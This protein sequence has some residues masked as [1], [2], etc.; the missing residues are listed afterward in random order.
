L[1]ITLV[2]DGS[3]DQALLPAV[4]WLLTEHGVGDALDARWADFRYR[5]KPPTDLKGKILTAIDL[6]PCDLLFVH[7]DAENASRER[8]KREID[9]IVREIEAD[10]KIPMPAVCVVPVRMMEAWLLVDE[11]AI[12]RA[13]GNPAGKMALG[14]PRINRIESTPDPKKALFDALATASGYT[15]RRLAKLNFPA[16]RYRVA[17]LISD[18]SQLRRLSAFTALEAEV[19][20]VLPL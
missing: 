2:S 14:L 6:Y 18:H 5:L 4:K 3:S 16:L 10:G 20:S 19:E 13:A 9:A 1:K 11:A 8:R 15:G 17:E 7:R 12:R